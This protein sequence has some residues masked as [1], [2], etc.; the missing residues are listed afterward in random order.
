M[1]KVLGDCSGKSDLEIL[2]SIWTSHRNVAD[3]TVQF[4]LGR[5]S[6]EEIS[7]L[8]ANI[9]RFFDLHGKQ[10]GCKHVRELLYPEDK[11]AVRAAREAFWPV[12][13]DG[14]RRT[15]FLIYRRLRVMYPR[16]EKVIDT[17]LSD[18]ECETLVKLQ[19]TYGNDWC[20]IAKLMGR[21]AE[22]LRHVLER[23]K[24]KESTLA[25]DQK[26]QIIKL[27]EQGKSFSEIATAVGLHQRFC[28]KFYSN[29]LRQTQ[30]P[31]ANKTQT[32]TPSAT[33]LETR[34]AQ[35]HLV[36]IAQDDMLKDT[37]SPE[38][39][40]QLQQHLQVYR[41]DL[42]KKEP[43]K[44]RAKRLQ[45]YRP[46]FEDQRATKDR[47]HDTSRRATQQ[48]LTTLHRLL[49][50]N[51]TLK[52]AAFFEAMWEMY[53]EARVKQHWRSRPRTTKLLAPLAHSKFPSF[54]TLNIF[55]AIRRHG[56]A[57]FEDIDWAKVAEEANIA[58][59]PAQ[60]KV[61]CFTG[62][63]SLRLCVCPRRACFDRLS[64][65]PTKQT[66]P[67]PPFR[68]THSLLLPSSSLPPPLKQNDRSTCCGS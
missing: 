51:D 31:H 28:R 43:E 13:F 62:P 48:Q 27:K 60:I 6:E 15:A 20:R 26:K 47:L 64:N 56:Y 33:T 14:I 61:S 2:H 45:A 49:A 50:A 30:K 63:S 21:E 35:K 42:C 25:E 40:A 18:E 16:F 5:W 59:S 41:Q 37:L 67:P 58:R 4:K 46:L 57:K 52:L 68:I 44:A 66:K 36:K 11:A 7:R 38:D 29:H 17:P 54:E 32:K 9:A 65:I 55:V 34:L 24:A 39:A 19:E 1:V 8:E 53:K 23:L 10:F 12:A 3:L 22:S